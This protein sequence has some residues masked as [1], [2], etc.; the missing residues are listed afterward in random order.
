MPKYV[1]PKRVKEVSDSPETIASPSDVDDMSWRRRLH[2]IPVNKEILD[3]VEVD[4]EYEVLIKATIVGLDSNV[5]ESGKHNSSI[6][7][8]MSSIEIYP[9]DDNKFS[10][11]SKDD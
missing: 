8:D 4:G 9:V 2:S 7:L 5:A 6:D 11:L 3:S 1:L 10:E